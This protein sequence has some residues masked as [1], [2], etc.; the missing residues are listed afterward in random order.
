MAKAGILINEIAWMGTLPKTG[1]S[2]QAAAN[3]EW[4]EL[5]N[6]GDSN[7]LLGGWKIVAEDGAPDIALSGT[8][9]AGGYFLLERSSDEVVPA[10]LAD[11]IYPYKNNALSNSGE[12]LFLKDASG[13]IIDEVDAHLGWPAGD[14][15]TKET[16][17]RSG[18]KWITATGT[19]QALNY[20][21]PVAS[22]IPSS[23]SPQNTTSA[24]GSSTNGSL[25]SL[26]I[27]SIST[28]AGEDL[29][30]TVGSNVEFL[31]NALGFKNEPLENAR[32]WW[33]FGDGESAEGRSVSHIFQAPARYTVGLHISSGGNSASDYM[34]AEIDPNQVEIASVLEGESGFIRLFNPSLNTIDIG[35]WSI[36]NSSGK[37][38]MV[39]PKTKI[40]AKSEIALTHSVTGLWQKDNFYP[41]I[42]RYPNAVVAFKFSSPSAN[43]NISNNAVNTIAVASSSLGNKF[44]TNSYDTT[45]KENKSVQLKIIEA[46]VK[47]APVNP[48]KDNFA[49]VLSRALN[50]SSIFF[51][52]A[53]IISFLAGLGF[54]FTKK[55]INPKF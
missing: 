29:T 21:P 19:P 16:M 7:I 49:G 22:S 41:L 14:N 23:V 2:P 36:E 9:S 17:Q 10:I 54:I 6:S 43:K 4:I 39:L 27:P 12:H 46:P 51:L 30:A 48:K 37:K 45:D 8:I 53:F 31:G 50:S 47:E 1:E 55:W 40:A 11:L 15:D 18:N 13:A 5:Y 32:F 33:N 28:Y 38:F 44:F 34:I 35:F 42:V 3:N 24:G 52:I 26:V 25:I 20:V